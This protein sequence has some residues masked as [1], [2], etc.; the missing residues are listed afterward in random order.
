MSTL[1]CLLRANCVTW[2]SSRLY[3]GPP[4]QLEQSERDGNVAA[5]PPLCSVEAMECPLTEKRDPL[6]GSVC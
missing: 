3:A 2:K 6:M 1:A 5:T 4:V